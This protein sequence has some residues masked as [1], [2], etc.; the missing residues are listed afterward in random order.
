MNGPRE[1][2]QFA[3][4]PALLAALPDPHVMYEV[5]SRQHAAVLARRDQ[6][7]EA[8]ERFEARHGNG[9]ADE[10]TAAKATDFLH[11]LNREA[12]RVEA[13]RK[14]VKAPILACGRVLDR[15]L[16]NETSDRLVSAGARVGRLLAAYQH[17]RLEAA[18]KEREEIARRARDAADKLAAEAL[19]GGD[20]ALLRHAHELDEAAQRAELA[21]TTGLAEV[22]RTRGE[23][24]A[25]ASLKDDWTYDVVA[26][27]A[28]PREWLTIDDRRVRAAIRGAAGIRDIPGLRI[29]NEP[30]IL[31]ALM[32]PGARKAADQGI[33]S[34]S[35]TSLSRGC[36]KASPPAG[37]PPNARRRPGSARRIPSAA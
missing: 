3:G 13:I 9:I 34:R 7:L 37:T 30:K 15:L 31:R 29:Y 1:K 19:E 35:R 8:M 10:E 16:K 33:S 24:G 25:V 21:A 18:R 32:R 6:L 14:S 28:V 20:A 27:D 5:L 4:M 17:G 12:D 36:P 26:F 23:T 2:E 22:A 11:M